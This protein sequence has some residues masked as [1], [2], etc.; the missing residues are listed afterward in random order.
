MFVNGLNN[1]HI[2]YANVTTL[3]LLTHFY[4]NY[5][6]I[7]D[8][9]LINNKNTL[10]EPYDVNLPIEYFFMLIEDCVDYSQSG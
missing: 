3:Q 2:G 7:I 4:N 8:S 6:K 1:R 9:D 10:N 5:A